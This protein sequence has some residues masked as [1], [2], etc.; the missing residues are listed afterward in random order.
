MNSTASPTDRN[1]KPLAERTFQHNQS[2]AFISSTGVSGEDFNGDYKAHD[3]GKRFHAG[4]SPRCITDTP[5]T[6]KTLLCNEMTRD[7]RGETMWT[8]DCKYMERRNNARKESYQLCPLHSQK[9]P[10]SLLG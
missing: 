2:S 1:L 5:L 3:G 10:I 6:S 8:E 4:C 9:K 7:E